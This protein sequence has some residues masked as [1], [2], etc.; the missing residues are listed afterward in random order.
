MVLVVV[1]VMMG[2]G[3]KTWDGTYNTK[4]WC[5]LCSSR[6]TTPISDFSSP[7]LVA[8]MDATVS[9]AP[10]YVLPRVLCAF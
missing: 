7:A 8:T 3:F 9:V 6:T 4:S 1:V 2:F 10:F 5:K